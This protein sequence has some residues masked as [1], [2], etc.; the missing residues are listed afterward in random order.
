MLFAKVKSMKTTW[1]HIGKRTVWLAVV[2]LGLLATAA[3]ADEKTAFELI[4]EGNRYVGEQASNKVVQIRCDK[5][6]GG[7]TPNIWYIVYYDHTAALNAVEV[8]FGAG[9]MLDVKRPFRLLEPIVGADNPFK[10]EQLKIDSDEAFNIAKK[11][12]LLDKLE[13]KAVRMKMER[14]KDDTTPVWKVRLWVAKL[15]EPTKTVDIGEI[16]LSAE[17]GKIIKVDLHINKVG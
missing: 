8:K 2:T 17:D 9:R 1:Q 16:I 14:W 6:V 3:Q 10:R 11:E 15:N 5:S 7:T 12:P 13:I 4:D